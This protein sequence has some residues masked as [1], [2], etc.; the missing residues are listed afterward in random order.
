[1]STA[2]KA[3]PTVKPEIVGWEDAPPES[4]TSRKSMWD[5]VIT[6]VYEREDG[7][8]AKVAKPPRWNSSSLSTLR[9]KHPTLQFE[10]PTMAR[11]RGA[12]AGEFV[13]IRKRVDGDEVDPP[14]AV[15]EALTEATEEAAA[16][17]A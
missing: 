5:D 2:V 6:Q 13:W 17:D 9:K 11:G 1:M 7:K 15:V 10:N 14:E 12:K 8:W 16:E 3:E 4:T